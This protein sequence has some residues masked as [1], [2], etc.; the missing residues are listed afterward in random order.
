MKT[1]KYSGHRHKNHKVSLLEGFLD[2][3]FCKCSKCD[4]LQSTGWFR[5][6]GKVKFD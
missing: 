3:G 5:H 2:D 1:Q 4:D 6:A